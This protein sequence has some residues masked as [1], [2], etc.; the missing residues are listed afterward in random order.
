[1]AKQKSF[2]KSLAELE[3]LVNAMEKGDMNLEDSLKAFEQ[4]VKL[5]QECQTDLANAELRIQTLLENNGELSSAP[6]D[7]LEP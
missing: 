7:D 6:L 3:Q 5:T 2:E 4:G 1:M